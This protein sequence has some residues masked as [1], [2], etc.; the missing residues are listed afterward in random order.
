MLPLA[1]PRSATLFEIGN[2]DFSQDKRP[3]KSSLFKHSALLS[4]KSVIF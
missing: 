1:K 4:E 2:G 3:A